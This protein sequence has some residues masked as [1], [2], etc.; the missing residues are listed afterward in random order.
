MRKC[1]GCKYFEGLYFNKNCA[2]CSKKFSIWRKPNDDPYVKPNAIECE[3]MPSK[4]EEETINPPSYVNTFGDYELHEIIDRYP[5]NWYEGNYFKYIIRA[6]NKPGISAEEDARKAIRY[7][8]LMGD[9]YCNM[10]LD[11]VV[12][13]SGLISETDLTSD[14]KILLITLLELKTGMTNISAEELI[15]TTKEYFGL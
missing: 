15:K 12:M 10:L 3:G 9:H 1:K 5:L 13:L 4:K 2:Y 8:E 14:K 11:D 6:G 7:I